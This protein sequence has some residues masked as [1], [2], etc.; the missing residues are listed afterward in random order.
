MHE[1]ITTFTKTL[2][3]VHGCTIS[4]ICAHCSYAVALVSHMVIFVWTVVI[5]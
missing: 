2:S 3:A 4:I 1:Y 5:G